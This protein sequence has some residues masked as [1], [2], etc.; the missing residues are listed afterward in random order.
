MFLYFVQRQ[1]FLIMKLILSLPDDTEVSLGQLKRLNESVIDRKCSVKVEATSFCFNNNL[2]FSSNIIFSCTVLFLF[3]K[4]DLHAFQNVL[5]LQ[6]ILS[7]L[8][9]YNLAYLFRFST[10][11]RYRLNF[12]KSLGFFDL[13]PLCSRRDPV[14]IWLRRFLKWG[15]SKI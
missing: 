1:V 14:I 12:A 10:K 2:F 5:E 4:Y 9:Y 11:F 13:F 8:K 7:L 3:E 6:S 15:L